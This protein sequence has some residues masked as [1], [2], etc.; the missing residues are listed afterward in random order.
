MKNTFFLLV[1]LIAS[2]STTIIHAE[3]DKFDNQS[4]YDFNYLHLDN[5][6]DDQN[7]KELLKL[8]QPPVNG[9]E[10]EGGSGP[11]NG[12]SEEIDDSKKDAKSM[13]I[14]WFSDLSDEERTKLIKRLKEI[15]NR[16]YTDKAINL[17]SKIST[18]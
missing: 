15:Y 2:M 11:G 7:L 10:G 9:V 3:D 4:E 16:D 1:I 12:V 14:R 8:L 13:L 5:M 17:L 6:S 18:V